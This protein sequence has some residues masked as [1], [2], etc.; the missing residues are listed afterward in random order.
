MMNRQQRLDE[1]EERF[2]ELHSE[3][4]ALIGSGKAHVERIRTL[5]REMVQI[6]EDIQEIKQSLSRPTLRLV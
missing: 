3:N 1:L 2:A 6:H 4:A 5:S